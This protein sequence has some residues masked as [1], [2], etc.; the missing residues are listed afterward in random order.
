MIDYETF[1]KIKVLKDQ[2]ALKC[3]QIAREL[4]LDNRTVEKWLK[5]E[6]YQQRNSPPRASKLDPFKQRIVRMLQTY[7][8]SAAQIFQRLKEDDFDGGYTIVKEY[9]RK[10][11]A[12]GYTGTVMIICIS[13]LYWK[14]IFS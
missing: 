13:I 5:K 11:R 7:P 2:H 10:V 6:R 14:C 1:V 12:S 3:S 4:N 8:Y 9:V